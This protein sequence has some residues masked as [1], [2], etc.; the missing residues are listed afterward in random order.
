[1]K[2]LAIMGSPHSGNTLEITQRIE[3]KLRQ[4]GDIEFEYI[5]LKDI[6]LKPCRGCFQCFI[7]GEDSCPLKDDRA[8]ISQKI[9]EADGVIFVTP[10]YSMHVSYLMKMFI[11]RFAY[12]FHRPR[13]FGKYALTVAAA[14]GIGLKETLKYL[15]MVTTGWGFDLVGELG[16]MAPPKNTLYGIMGKQKD[17]TDEMVSRF[18]TAIKEK[19][20]KKLTLT[21]H[22]TFRAMRAVY[23]RLKTASPIDYRYWEERGW[24]K[25]DARYFCAN[26][27]ANFF[28]DTIAR[29]IA[30]MVSRQMNKAE[31]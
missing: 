25:K 12:I 17:R 21:D 4:L 9:E 27:R 6:N 7:K 26:V 10:V 30:L 22:I 28:K 18:Y 3:T 16:I 13:Y 31:A 29:I 1:M 15:K 2:I 14:G 24:L 11:D 8:I 23:S 19:K 5:H 20:P